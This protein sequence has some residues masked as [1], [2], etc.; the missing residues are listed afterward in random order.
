[1]NLRPLARLL[2]GSKFEFWAQISN[3]DHTPQI[4]QHLG[5]Q[6]LEIC[7]ACHSYKFDL[8]FTPTNGTS[9]ANAIATILQFAP[10][11][12]SSNI[13]FDLDLCEMKMDLPIE[14]IANWLNRTFDRTNSSEEKQEA[15]FLQIKISEI[16]NASKMLDHLRKV[17]LF[18]KVRK[19]IF[20]AHSHPCSCPRR[21]KYGWLIDR[22]IKTK[23]SDDI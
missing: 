20:N 2:K 6:L 18:S 22:V 11:N 4:L 10:I 8:L 1:M 9:A 13:V 14:S 12:G 23:E 17:Y 3:S 16:S 5:N 21:R 19:I 15:R 7:N